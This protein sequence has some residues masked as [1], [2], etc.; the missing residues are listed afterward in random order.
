MCWLVW[1]HYTS[2]QTILLWIHHRPPVIIAMLSLP[3]PVLRRRKVWPTTQLMPAYETISFEHSQQGLE[4]MPSGSTL[5]FSPPPHL[6]LPQRF[7][8]SQPPPITA[9]HSLIHSYLQP[10]L[11]PQ[12]HY[13]H[14][15]FY[16]QDRHHHIIIL[17]WKQLRSHHICYSQQ[18]LHPGWQLV[19]RRHCTGLLRLQVRLYIGQHHRP[20]RLCIG[21]LRLRARLCIGPL[22]LRVR[23]CI[24]PLRLQVLLCT[25]WPRPQIRCCTGWLH[26]QLRLCAGPQRRLHHHWITLSGLLARI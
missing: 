11:H 17:M 14:L 23:L 25:G 12:Q 22:R 7:L 20:V 5:R 6:P 26:L 8:H 13:S 9:R 21:R 3:F 1:Y 18:E 16:S 10:L 24:G 19:R 15:I 4:T 2:F